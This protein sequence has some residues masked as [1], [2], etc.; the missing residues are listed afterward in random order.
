MAQKR[1][2]SIMSINNTKSSNLHLEWYY[3]QK[4]KKYDAR[5]CETVSWHKDIRFAQYGKI[6]PCTSQMFV[7]RGAYDF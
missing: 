7:F 4:V 1:C 3:S 5:W 2:V 6:K